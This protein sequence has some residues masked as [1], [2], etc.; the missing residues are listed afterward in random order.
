MKMKIVYSYIP[1]FIVLFCGSC[2]KFIDVNQNP[3][4]P[5]NVQESLILA[6]SEVVV[7]N[8]LVAGNAAIIIQEYLQVVALN[9]PV[10]QA[11]TYLL[12][13]A[14]M[15]G[16]W[17]TFYVTALNNLQMLNKNAEADGK[18][19]YA[20]IAKI[21]TALTLGTA[22][23]IWGDVPYSQ[24]F[25]GSKNFKPVYDQQKDVYQS[26]Q[27]LL[28]SSILDMAK[29]SAIKPG[30]D[31]YFYQGDMDKWKRLAYTLKARYYMH[32]TK[33]PG[34][35][36]A[37]Q[38]DLALQALANGMTSNDDDL[39]LSFPGTPGQENIWY[40]NFM[41]VSTLI[42]ASHFVDGLK[43]TNDPRL[44][45]MVRPAE[46]TGLYTGRQIGSNDVGSLE[47]YSRPNDFYAGTSAYNY[48]VNY[49]EALFLK[50]EATYI[51]S[52]ADAAQPIF[53]EAIKSHMDKLGI[54]SAAANNYLATRGTLTSA[55]ALQRIMEEKSIANFLNIE[56]FTD[57]RRTGYPALVKVPN[58]LSDIPRRLLYPQVEIISN[59]QP[60]QS[61]TLT[62]R[63]WWDQ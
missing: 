54:S 21:L 5:E 16:D 48:L 9:Q 44:P 31:D 2:K 29:Q 28:D 58:A 23:D 34:H 61:A 3:N 63:V 41:P 7:S 18:S 33:A 56:N 39:K 11:G 49:S 47:S 60:Q 8:S 46:E 42:L 35:T 40:Q 30:S 50:A 25:Q 20:A 6:P 26:I 38:A 55:N 62:S 37:A 19:N 22:T 32:L 17:S 24:A 52:G 51:K 43:A 12:R 4:N 1:V 45:V 53:Q 27:N 57:W 13:N 36:A 14:D 15:D 59:P 10:P